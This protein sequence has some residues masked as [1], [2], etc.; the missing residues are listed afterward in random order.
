LSFF[1]VRFSAPLLGFVIVLASGRSLGLRWLD[2][3]SLAIAAALGTGLV[4]LLRTDAWAAWLGRT[5]G[6]VVHRV[7]PSVEPD[8]WASACLRFRGEIAARFGYAFPRSVAALL[9]MLLADL[10]IM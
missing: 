3:I 7:R 10:S 4:L 2:L 9:L 6:R 1:I 5:G 8:R